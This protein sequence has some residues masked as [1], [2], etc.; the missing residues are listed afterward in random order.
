MAL[1]ELPSPPQ[2]SRVSPSPSPPPPAAVDPPDIAL[3]NRTS[4]R[5]ALVAAVLCPCHLWLVA[6]AMSLFGAG[7]MAT[8]VRENQLLLATVL[9]PLTAVALWRAVT[10]GRRAAALKGT[11]QACGNG[12]DGS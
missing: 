1:A 2:D 12:C 10:S 5:W 11:G 3:Q 4:K 6:G 8:A 9:A 7:A